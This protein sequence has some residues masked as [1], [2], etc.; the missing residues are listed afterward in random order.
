MMDTFRAMAPVEAPG[1]TRVAADLPQTR[2]NMAIIVFT[3]WASAGLSPSVNSTTLA[4]QLPTQYGLDWDKL[5]LA[6]QH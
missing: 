3:D 1:I 4:S 6:N 2:P 5:C